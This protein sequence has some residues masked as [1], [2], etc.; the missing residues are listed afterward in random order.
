MSSI[1]IRKRP[2]YAAPR[3]KPVSYFLSDSLF[4]MH[5]FNNNSEWIM[6]VTAY[7]GPMYQL[8]SYNWT[9]A[10]VLAHH[11][12]VD[13]APGNIENRTVGLTGK[14]FVQAIAVS[15]PVETDSIVSVRQVVQASPKSIWPLFFACSF[16]ANS[17]LP[18]HRHWLHL[19]ANPAVSV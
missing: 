2:D 12:I 11:F 10:L 7:E 1:K 13:V 9:W 4:K 18:C 5:R 6:A 14:E 17:P 8:M 15:I 3:T 16:A 19:M